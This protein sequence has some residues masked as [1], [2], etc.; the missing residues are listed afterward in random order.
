MHSYPRFVSLFAKNRHLSRNTIVAAGLF[1][2]FFVT[3]KEG[4]KKD[5]KP[6]AKVKHG[7]PPT[8]VYT[9]AWITNDSFANTTA[10]DFDSQ[11]PQPIQRIRRQQTQRKMREGLTE[12][13]LGCVYN[14]EWNRPLGQGGF[15]AVYLGEDKRTGALGKSRPFHLG[16]A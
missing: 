16:N 12:K 13:K 4:K 8:E 7:A 6:N 11:P 15:G 9:A 3:R 1:S 14:V 2:A 5:C 10:C